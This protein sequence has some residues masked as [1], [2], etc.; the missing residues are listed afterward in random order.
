M[1]LLNSTERF[2]QV[3]YNKSILFALLTNQNATFVKLWYY[4]QRERVIKK[5]KNNHLYWRKIFHHS[6]Y[7]FLRGRILEWD[8]RNHVLISWAC[9]SFVADYRQRTFWY[10][11]TRNINNRKR[12]RNIGNEP[13]KFVSRDHR[14]SSTTRK[15]ISEYHR[16][17][18]LGHIKTR[19]F[20]RP[21]VT[22]SGTEP[23]DHRRQAAYVNTSSTMVGD[24]RRLSTISFS[25]VLRVF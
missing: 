6:P 1:V 20:L 14:R 4:L 25:S 2:S 5:E 24:G 19:L 16:W 10:I 15:S 13:K 22:F 9:F 21:Q 23:V 3:Y 11:R 17:T 12:S 18:F 8:R 7:N